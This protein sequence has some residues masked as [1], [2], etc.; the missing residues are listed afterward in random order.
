M[1][2]FALQLKHRRGLL[3]CLAGILL[4][5]I[6]YFLTEEKQQPLSAEEQQLM[7]AWD[8][9]TPGFLRIFRADRTFTTSNGQFAGR[10][11]IDE[12]ELK[13]TYWQTFEPPRSLSLTSLE[14]SLTSLQRSFDEETYSWQIDFLK[15]GQQMTL[16][17]PVDEQH[18]DGKWLW[19]K[20]IDK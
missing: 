20:Q 17:H 15:N 10:W 19:T 1:K 3:V 8:D 12:G 6:A 7:G 2:T 16:S 9:E 13:V 18:P 14:L 11:W 5:G 4:L